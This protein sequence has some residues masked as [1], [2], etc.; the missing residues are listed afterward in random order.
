MVCPD[1]G[2][3]T[4]FAART[5]P[6]TSAARIE[7]HLADCDDCR[8]LVFALASVSDTSS[9]GE[10][11]PERIGRFEVVDVIGR[12]AMGVVYRARDP[13]LDRLVA[14]KVRRSQEGGLSLAAR[15]RGLTPARTAFPTI[16]AST[17]PTARSSRT[18]A[19]TRTRSS[20]ACS[21]AA[22]SDRRRRRSRYG[23]IS[24]SDTPHWRP[25]A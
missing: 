16:S 24:W 19:K 13:E 22:G 3:I 6:A 1:E 9:A 8:N 20:R 23:R 21:S 17:P 25:L 7:S 14:I 5:L 15:P 10:L 2:E 11:S 18:R 12:G 4:A